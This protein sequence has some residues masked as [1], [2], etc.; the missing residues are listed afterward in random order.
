MRKIKILL[1]KG[2]TVDLR[3][4]KQEEGVWF[5]VCASHNTWGDVDTWDENFTE[6]I[7]KLYD[8]A[9]DLESVWR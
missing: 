9:K 5:N 1:N 6:A 3:A 4:D 7:D 2:W 8:G